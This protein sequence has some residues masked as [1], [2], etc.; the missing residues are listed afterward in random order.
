MPANNG[1]FEVFSLV[2]QHIKLRCLNKNKP[3]IID[4]P[5]TNGYSEKKNLSSK[6]DYEPV[7][8]VIYSNWR[9]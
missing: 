6:E 7:N 1:G 3:A 4:L 9:K 2:N 8:T 5:P